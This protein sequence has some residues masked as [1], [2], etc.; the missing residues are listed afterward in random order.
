M[1]NLENFPKLKTLKN[2][3][4][5]ENSLQGSL[6]NLMPLGNLTYLNLA[7]NLIN[8]FRKLQPLQMIDS[9]EV[10]LIG[11]PFIDGEVWKSKVKSY[12]IKVLKEPK[13]L[14]TKSEVKQEE[15][16][17]EKKIVSSPRVKEPPSMQANN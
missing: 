4:I 16:K 14:E 15:K 17:E 2:L 12:G 6:N 3:D 7:N 13:V 10:Y 9:L 1:R 8:D 5:S 11:N